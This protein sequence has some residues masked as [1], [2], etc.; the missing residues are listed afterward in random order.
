MKL[1]DRTLLIA[2]RA[3]AIWAAASWLAWGLYLESMYDYV[4]YVAGDAAGR[5]IFFT[6]AVVG[7][8]GGAAIL[9]AGLTM[10][11][12]MM[13]AVGMFALASGILL[14]LATIVEMA[15]MRTHGL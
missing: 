13:T 8:V 9:I 2:T 5:V 1:N 10:G 15:L 7:I 4:S 12:C 11:R 14:C 6:P 3:V